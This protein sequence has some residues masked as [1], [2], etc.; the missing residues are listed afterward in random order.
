[1]HRNSFSGGPLMLRKLQIKSTSAPITFYDL[2]PP[3]ENQLFEVL[4]ALQRSP[5]SISPKYFYDETGSN[6]FQ[7][8]TQL[9]EYY[10]TRTEIQILKEYSQ[11]IASLF[12]RDCTLIEYGCGSSNKIE[13]L[14]NT[15]PNTTT[16]V[17]ID[18]S[19]KHLLDLSQ[20]LSQSHPLLDIL[21]ICADF[22]M[23]L[24]L[25]L[26]ET[27]SGNKIVF[28]PGSSIGNFD[29]PEARHFLSNILKTVGRDGGLLIGVD[30]KKERSILEAAYNDAHGITARFNLNLLRRINQECE[31]D[32]DLQQFR[33]QAFYNEAL[34]RIEMHLVSLI[35]Q[36][37]H[38]GG[39]RISFKKDETIHT[40]NSYKYHIEEFQQLAREVGW[41]PMKVWTDPN[42]YFSLHY[43]IT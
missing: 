40:E 41:N 13:I 18:I 6:L 36:E 1:M 8:I 28:F 39:K 37:V 12:G 34:S 3:R 22:T 10:L 26:S 23:H 14:L 27:D 25:P 42:N 4:G 29:P 7:E 19:R 38:L 33:H 15:L 20:N 32:F 17:A 43:M 24:D 30:L 16:Y 35:D 31:A 21:A 5:K 11:K 2:Y 9:E